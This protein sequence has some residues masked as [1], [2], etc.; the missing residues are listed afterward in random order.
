MAGERPN[1]IPVILVDQSN[2]P[3]VDDTNDAVRVYIVASDLS[4]SGGTSAADDADFVAGTTSGTPVMGVY[5]SSPTSVTDGDMGVVGITATRA[6]KVNVTAGTAYL[7]KL[8]PPDIDVTTHTNYTR[9]YYTASAPTDGIVWSPA[10]G[11]RWHITSFF[12]GVGSA[13]TVTLEDDKS[14]GDDPVWKMEFT[15]NSG[16]SQSFDPLYP[17]ASGEDAADLI[18][19]CSAGNVYVTVIGY[20]V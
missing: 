1:P 20:E 5:E 19:T 11:K 13:C 4:S 18:V 9:K 17:L 10:S 6:L 16:W 15:A 14:G 8:L 2:D 7:G 3:V 12:V